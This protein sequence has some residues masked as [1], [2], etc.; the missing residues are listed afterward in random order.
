MRTFVVNY[1]N[2]MSSPNKLSIHN[3]FFI[4]FIIW[5]SHFEFHSRHGFRFFLPSSI[6]ASFVGTWKCAL[7]G[8]G[9]WVHRSKVSVLDMDILFVC[10]PH[11]YKVLMVWLAWVDY[12][13][14]IEAIGIFLVFLKYLIQCRSEVSFF[15]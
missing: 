3:P 13:L 4:L 6:F 5:T 2:L 14:Q 1:K 12:Q 11:F 10:K 9:E 15:F 8:A 7:S